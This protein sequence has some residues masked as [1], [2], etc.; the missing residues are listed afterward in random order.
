MI[1]R[2]IWTVDALDAWTRRQVDRLRADKRAAIA[3]AFDLG[4]VQRA[5]QLAAAVERVARSIE[6]HHERHAGE[7]L[8]AIVHE[9]SARRAEAA[10]FRKV[11]ATRGTAVAN[12]P[13]LPSVQ[14]RAP[15]ARVSRPAQ[16]GLGLGGATAAPQSPSRATEQPGRIAPWQRKAGAL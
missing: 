1:A 6:A 12:F 5:M 13:P 11:L 16:L 4:D 8:Y 2:G 10:H 14:S 15:V 7:L 9:C 3:S